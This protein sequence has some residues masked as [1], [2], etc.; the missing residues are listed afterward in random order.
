MRSDG[1]VYYQVSSLEDLLIIIKHLDKYP[2]ITHKWADFE[3]FKLVVNMMLNKEHLTEEGLAKI[4]NIKAAMNFGVISEEILSRFI[5]VNPVKRP[6]KENIQIAHPFWVSGFVEGEGMFFI[7]IYKRK[8]SKL[9]EGVK[10]VFKVTQDLRNKEVLAMFESIFSCGKV[11]KQSPSAKVY[12]FL[13]TGL[14]DIL[15]HVIPFFLSHP[16][17]GAK[18]N[19]FLDFIKV[20]ELMKAKAHLN[21]DGLE[22]IRLIKSGMNRGRELP[23]VIE[24]VLDEE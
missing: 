20:A 17:E 9:G 22:Q 13:I 3:L 23:P 24:P 19:E 4:V 15:K 5:N 11:Y 1:A 12:D 21:E 8:D 14:S 6:I 7:N 16:L 18:H 2:L 10:I